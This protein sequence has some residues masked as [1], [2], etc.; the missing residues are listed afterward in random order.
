MLANEKDFV[1]TR[2][3]YKLSLT[4]PSLSINTACS[5]SLVAVIQAVQSL[6]TAQCDIALAGGISITTP[7]YRGYLYQEGSMLSPDGHCRPFDA[8]AEG[9]MFNSG[10]GIVVLKR[11]ADALEDGD[12]IY[13]V[14]WGAG[15]N[16]DGADKVSFTA[17]SVNGQAN[18]IARAQ[19]QAGFHPETLSYIEAHGTATPLGDPIEV[20]ALTQAF[21]LQT[22]AVQFCAIG[23]VKGNVGH[24]VAAA[25]V[26]GLI[27]TALAL[28]HQKIPPSLNFK[29]AN[30]EIDFANS[31][32]F[33]NA[34]LTGWQAG[35]TPRRAGVSSFGVGGTNAHVVLE[36]SPTVAASSPS[37]P[38]Q[39]LLLS[40]K[41][42]TALEQAMLQLTNHLRSQPQI[43]L[44][45]VA[46][47]LQQGRK[48]FNHRRFVVCGDTTEAIAI[49]ESLDANR[50]ATRHTQARDPEVAFM[51]P[52][53]GSQYVQMGWNLYQHESV[54]R[55]AIDRCAEILKPM[56]MRDLREVMYPSVTGEATAHATAISEATAALRQTQYTQPALFT[57]EYA[58]AQLWQKLGNSAE[59]HDRA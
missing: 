30:P 48:T 29:V 2:T 9:T 7:Q 55:D 26:T 28:Y 51:F 43:N 50:T 49:L 56:L 27:K 15:M 20:E 46:H 40:A 41:T 18:A 14:I 25:G 8:N 17:P 4:G 37:R 35:E 1:T 16:N 11:L 21:R 32:F 10:A 23:S 45:D 44:A 58:L 38:R 3:S 57:I 34:K 42:P 52:G 19:A 31:P 47:T 53:Q 5:T 39:L 6:M 59:C 22:N 13:A 24:L 36:E 12:R 33:V 54:F